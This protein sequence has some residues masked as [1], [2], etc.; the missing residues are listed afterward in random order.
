[1]VGRLEVHDLHV[2]RPSH[3]TQEG[4]L[5]D[6][7]LGLHVAVDVEQPPFSL[8][9]FRSNPA[10]VDGLEAAA[11]RMVVVGERRLERLVARGEKQVLVVEARE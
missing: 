7:R 4:Q 10:C 2:E 6:D 3:T 8:C 5:L 1:M 11:A 9:P